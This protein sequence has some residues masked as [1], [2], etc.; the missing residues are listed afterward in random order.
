VVDSR[1]LGNGFLLPADPLRE[2]AW[3][4]RSV[5]A[6]VS[7]DSPSGA[8]PC[9]SKASAA[10]HDGCPRAPRRERLF[11]PEVTPSPALAIQTASSCTW[12]SLGLR[13][14]RIPLLITMRSRPRDL[15]FGDNLPV[16]MTEIR[17]GKIAPRCPA[18]VW[19]LP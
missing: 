4:L 10:P 13:V 3:R 2:P 6:V 19:V 14:L 18:A 12:R 11:R 1:G 17:R 7:H 5:D 8:I 9:S 15:E 16:L